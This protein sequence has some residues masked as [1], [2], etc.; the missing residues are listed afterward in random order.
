MNFVVADLG[1]S[2]TRYASCKGKPSIIPNNMVFI[3]DRNPDTGEVK[4][5]LTPVKLHT[6]S[7]DINERLEFIIHKEDGNTTYF[8]MH[9]L[10]GSLADRHPKVTVRPDPTSKTRQRIYYASM[11]ASIALSRI[12]DNIDEDVM[13]YMALPP[14]ELREV[15]EELNSMICGHY[16]VEMPKVNEGTKVSFN[17]KEV[18]CFEESSC[19]ILSF[20]FTTSGKPKPEFAKFGNRTILSI[21]IGASTTDFAI[22]KKG[23]IQDKTSKTE[24]I[25]GNIVRDKV[26]DYIRGKF[27]FKLP[28]EEADTAITHGLFYRGIDP[29]P[30]GAILDKAKLEVAETIVEDLGYYFAG[31]D[32]PIETI[33]AIVVSGGGSMQSQYINEDGKVTVTSR[34]MSDFITEKLKE[35]FNINLLVVNHSDNPRMANVS[36]LFTRARLDE[37]RENMLEAKKAAEQKSETPEQTENNEQETVETV[38]EIEPTVNKSS[39]TDGPNIDS[40]NFEPEKMVEFS[41]DDK[42]DF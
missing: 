10:M 40:M 39:E 9:V 36:G 2:G 18:R 6:E 31:I 35:K 28:A 34:P 30:L 1:A 41:N 16:D 8:P 17:I 14:T 33:N 3:E 26:I 24:P 13:F 29:V 25:G 5:N 19:A 23:V 4:V 12:S 20:L 22:A 37:Y 27:G 42:M 15:S 11:V 38:I 21:D 32:T 7:D